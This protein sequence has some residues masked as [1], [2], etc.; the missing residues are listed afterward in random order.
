MCGYN[1]IF[2]VFFVAQMAKASLF[3]CCDDAIEANETR[4]AMTIYVNFRIHNMKL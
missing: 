2:F 1:P 3:V 4:L